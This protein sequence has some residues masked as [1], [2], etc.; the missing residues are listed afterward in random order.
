VS[1]PTAAAEGYAYLCFSYI[2]ISRD[3]NWLA[4]THSANLRASM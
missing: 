3:R 2:S 4:S 1:I